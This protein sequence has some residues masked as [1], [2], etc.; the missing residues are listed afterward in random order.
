VDLR[1][2]TY[3]RRRLMWF[4]ICVALRSLV[5]I[6]LMVAI[7]VVG[8]LS[9]PTVGVLPAPAAPE[10][11]AWPISRVVVRRKAVGGI[12]ILRIIPL[13]RVVRGR[14]DVIGSAARQEKTAKHDCELQVT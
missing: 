6:G 2:R 9:A 8:P 3:L 7:V 10:A 1:G 12:R 14:P 11:K 4:R 13:T 5:T